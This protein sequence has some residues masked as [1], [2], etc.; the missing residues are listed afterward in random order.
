MQGSI[1]QSL[2]K[3][4]FSE[5]EEVTKNSSKQELFLQFK[6]LNWHN[7]T[8][9]LSN[10]EAVSSSSVITVTHSR[11]TLKEDNYSKKR[12]KTVNLKEEF[13]TLI[14]LKTTK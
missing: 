7:S 2:W 10:H 6:E 13:W 11:S 9:L 8:T 5:E 14:K 1:E 3:S 4:E 12:G